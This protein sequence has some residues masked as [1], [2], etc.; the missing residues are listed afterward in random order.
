MKPRRYRPLVALAFALTAWCGALAQQPE[1]GPPL[2]EGLEAIRAKHGLPALAARGLAWDEGAGEPKTVAAAEVGR[3]AVGG[4][5]PVQPTDLWHIGSCTKALTATLLATYVA[6]G[7]LAWD[8]TLGEALPELAELMSPPVKARTVADLVRHQAGMPPNASPRLFG[9]LRVMDTAKGRAEVV[10]E[11]L[12]TAVA[13]HETDA[14]VY[15]NT[16][17][18][19]AGAICERLGGKPWEQLLSDRVLAPLGIEEGQ[20]GFGAPPAGRDM[21]MPDQPTGHRS[22]GR[23][24]G[25]QRWMPL[26]PNALA[27]NP[28]AYGPAGT[29][30]LTLDAWARFCMAHVRGDDLPPGERDALGLSREDYAELHRGQ[31]G[32]A[33]GWVV[34]QRA[35]A[36]PAEAGEAAIGGVLNH[37]GSNTFWYAVAWLAP[38]RD[39]VLLAVTN[40]AGEAGPKGADEAVGAALAGLAARSQ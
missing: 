9:Q 36:K 5:S 17:Y 10:R 37:A 8:D 11:A 13:V 7:K 27:D 1:A 21:T 4:E 25:G 40:A 39:L 35:W 15:S 3:R 26:A 34:G 24:A 29:L 18:V 38:E 31:K 30:H 33:A 2:A 16:G 12:M 28:A 32:F 22:V 6:E 19:V 23:G 14:P 20:F